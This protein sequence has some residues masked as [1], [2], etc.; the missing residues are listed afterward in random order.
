MKQTPVA[1]WEQ[2]DF[3]A[4][5]VRADLGRLMNCLDRG[6]PLSTTAVRSGEPAG[7]SGLVSKGPWERLVVSEW[8]LA[9]S[10]PEEFVRRADEGELGFW[11][12][13]KES[14][15]AA[16]SLWVWVD[17][18]PEQL[19]GC[20]V[21]QLAI[22]F[23][24]QKKCLDS[25]GQFYW[26]VVQ[27]PER[28]YDKLAAD[29]LH[30]FLKARSVD[31]PRRPPERMDSLETWCVGGLSWG[32]QIP[33]D[34]RQISL[35][36]IGTNLVELRAFGRR[37]ELELPASKQAVRLLRSPMVWEL[38]AREKP[39]TP[40]QKGSLAFS[41][42]AQK[43][44]IVS[45]RSVTTIPL[46][47]SLNE[48]PGRARVYPVP[49]EGRVIAVSLVRRAII[50]VLESDGHWMVRR[51]NP[52]QGGEGECYRVEAPQIGEQPL[53]HC[54]KS[55][56]DWAV[57]IA[58]SLYWLIDEPLF[59]TRVTGGCALGDSTILVDET[60]RVLNSTGRAISK[61]DH[62]QPAKAFLARSYEHGVQ[63]L[64]YCVATH[65]QDSWWRIHQGKGYAELQALGNV[66]GLY[67]DYKRGPLLIVDTNGWLMLQGPITRE[68]LDL[69]E[70]VES[71]V[72]H[73]NG[74]IA[75]RTR[76]GNFGCYDLE[77]SAVI[78]RGEV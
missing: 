61:L 32:S 31:P 12:L 42:C 10:Y 76:S 28:G 51:L 67:A 23:W 24:L 13:A 41:A 5:D 19:G 45:N 20:R 33:R 65:V 62:E 53:G 38:P 72:V 70:P 47:S 64:G 71:C 57:W 44:L 2:L 78:W 66:V 68:S 37:L 6:L 77:H 17:A 29:E 1:W 16:R 34:V 30:T 50:V 7:W 14:H 40:V 11:D 8:A 54:F 59:F 52:S 56:D 49:W 27:E 48:P 69:G 4:P 46:P 60:G 43:L 55:N 74:R 3:L 15:Q 73:P 35:E 39:V 26:G 22:L 9:Q 21:V 58:D 63:G 36:Q 18:G 25:G 75:Y